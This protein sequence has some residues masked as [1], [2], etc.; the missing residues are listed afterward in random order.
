MSTRVRVRFAP[1][2]T[3][4]L[5]VGG[6]RTALYNFLFAKRNNGVFVLRIEDTDQSRKVEGAVENLIRTLDWAGIHFDEGPGRDANYGP[7]VQSQRLTIYRDH[8][9]QLIRKGNAYYC[10]CTPERLEELRKQQAVE[11]KGQAYDRHCRALDPAESEKRA[12]SGERHV[13]RMKI[14]ESGE[15]TMRDVI[16]G[17]VTFKYDVLDDQVLIKSDGFPTYHLAVVVD[18]HLMEISHVIRGEEWLPSAPKHVLL[19]RYFGWELPVFAH[20]PLLLNPDKSKLSK[21]QGD[22][23]VEDYRA[24]GYLKEAIINFVA[25]LGWNPGDDREIFSME[26]LINEFDLERVGKA[27]AVFN[28]DKLNWLNQQHIMLKP[29][30][31]LAALVRPDLEASGITGIDESRLRA[32]VALMRERIPFVIGFAE[33]A[34]YLFVA[35]DTY[36]EAGVKKNWDAETG[37]RMLALAERLSAMNAF[38]T[39]EI[40]G[41]VKA[42]AEELQIKASKLIHPTRLAI[43]GRTGGP[44]LYELMAFLGKPEV[45]S[46]IRNAVERINV[47]VLGA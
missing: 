29:V 34:R 45:V 5:H 18:D 8:A 17:E 36:D 37:P 22:V 14:P 31:E 10:F 15:L 42:L 2:P 28:V 6:L 33:S 1:S 43:S 47:L 41:A 44:G 7:Y 23:A 16:R 32:A 9:H 35:P 46:R 19:Y 38:E 26:Q 4:Y 13:V 20:L 21:R 25:F 12:A 40:E 11:G 24:K 30:E 27:G 39:A 3:G